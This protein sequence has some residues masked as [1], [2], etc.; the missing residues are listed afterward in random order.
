MAMKKI[1]DK[2]RQK[3]IDLLQQ[4]VSTQEIAEIVDVTTRQVAAIKAHITMATYEDEITPPSNNYSSALPPP[5]ALIDNQANFLDEVPPILTD[6]EGKYSVP[7]GSEAHTGQHIFWNPDPQTGS[8]NPHLMIVG[9]SGYG[10][11]YALQC[12]VTELALR[13][14]PSI[15]I[16]Y[17]RGFDLD[18]APAQFIENARPVEIPVG[19]SGI[20]I[21]PLEIQ[22]TDPNGPLNV[23]VRISDSFSR[24]YRIG[25]QQHALLRD[26]IIETF[27][28]FGIYRDDKNSWK[29]SAPYFSDLDTLFEEIIHDRSDPRCRSVQTLKSHISTFFIFN[30]F[31]QTGDR[32]SWSK[33]IESGNNVFII[34][35]RGLEGRTEQVVTEFLLWDLYN[36][37]VRT[38][39]NPLRVFCILDEA[40]N[41]SF[42]QGTPV[43][44]LVREARK[45]GLGLI[46]SSQQPQDF[47]KVV[48]ANTASKLVFQTLDENQ[49]VAKQLAF[50]I[51][52]KIKTQDLAN[53]ISRLPRGEAFFIT[54]NYGYGI[55]I[56]SLEARKKIW[57]KLAGNR[58]S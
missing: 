3:I 48:Y 39:E 12:L 31:R 2:E 29:F 22:A 10:K 57:Q 38:G 56:D 21:N 4:G 23:A 30:T 34:Q 35:L 11:T 40:H 19:E 26:L 44:R 32:L 5:A 49:K 55:K 54:H 9:E 37:V 13:G 42:D 27:E 24:I 58:T 53:V 25:V 7:V 20:S 45:F 16:D 52:N 33:I 43:D 47:S 28:R 50:K 18:S 46:F 15:I 8:S 36:F 51:Q 1:T 41:L 14:I 6:P 17:G